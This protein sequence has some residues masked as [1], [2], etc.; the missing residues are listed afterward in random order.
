MLS[1][2]EIIKQKTLFPITC[3]GGMAII[4]IPLRLGEVVRPY[5]INKKSQITFTSS[6]ATIFLERFLIY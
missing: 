1:P 6:L 3:I 5:L 2:H 4:F